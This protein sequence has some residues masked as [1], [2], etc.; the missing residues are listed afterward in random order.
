MHTAKQLS[1]DQL[2]QIV[3]LVQRLL[4]LDRDSQ[5][6]PF[7]NPDRVW[8]GADVCQDL[9]GILSHYNLVPEESGPYS[10]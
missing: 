10:E 6:V 4:Y 1:R 7:W 2:R 5:G 9:A 8:S 3:D